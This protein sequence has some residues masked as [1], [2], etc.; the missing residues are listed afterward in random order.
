M[1][2]LENHWVR[3]DPLSTSHTDELWEVVKDL[4]IYKYSPNDLSTKDQLAAYIAIAV[5]NEAAGKDIP[6]AIF[7]KLSQKYVGS[8]RFGYIDLYNKT[9]HIGWT[10]L[11]KEVQGTGLNSAL[12]HLML[13]HAFE[14]MKMRKVIFRVDALNIRSRKA[15][16]KLG[17]TLEG[18]LK[19]DVFVAQKRIRDTCCYAIFSRDYS[20]K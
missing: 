13:L 18:I 15:L 7:N 12:K 1:L 9:L 17:A 5:A 14:V 19:E 3:L 16:E 6:F 4:D 8:T 10:W 20:S 2:P 11:A